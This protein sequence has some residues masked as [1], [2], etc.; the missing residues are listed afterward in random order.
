WDMTFGHGLTD[1]LSTEQYIAQS[2]KSRLLLILGEWYL[3][4]DDGTPWPAILGIKPYDPATAEAAVRDRILGTIGVTA[5][6]KF[7]ITFDAKTRAGKIAV[8][9]QTIYSTSLSVEVAV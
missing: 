8:T 9:V 5:I 1:Y 2:V 7:E 6:T 3:D 4:E